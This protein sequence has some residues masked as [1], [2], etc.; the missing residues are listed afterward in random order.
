MC[1]QW[2]NHT[3]RAPLWHG[4]DEH[5]IM[6][7]AGY[8][9]TC[10]ARRQP[11]ANQWQTSRNVTCQNQP[12]CFASS[13][14]HFARKLF[15]IRGFR[16]AAPERHCVRSGPS[17]PLWAMSDTS[18][19]VTLLS[20]SKP[21]DTSWWHF[22]GNP[23]GLLKSPACNGTSMEYGAVLWICVDLTWADMDQFNLLGFQLK[24]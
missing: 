12:Q 19:Y 24:R 23:G 9:S 11:I 20:K 21:Q 6:I 17:G 16:R 13:L 2:W 7:V 18:C 22:S 10:Q 14:S 4:C 15:Q 5:A 8:F 1:F 3:E